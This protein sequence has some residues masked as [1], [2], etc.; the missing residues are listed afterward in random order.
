MGKILGLD[1]KDRLE[2]SV[3]SIAAGILNG[4][5]IIRV[6]DVKEAR[7]AADMADAIKNS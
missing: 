2:G 6:H 1:A 3:A 7:M 5:G 4:A